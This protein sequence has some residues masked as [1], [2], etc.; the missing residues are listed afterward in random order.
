MNYKTKEDVQRV[1]SLGKNG[2]VIDMFVES[3][4]QG[5]EYEAWIETK[6]SEH[7]TLYPKQID[8]E[9]V[10]DADG[11]TVLYYEQI[12]NP[13]YVDFDTYMSETEQVQVGT[14]DILG[15]DG[16]TVTG[17]EPIY[18]E[19]LLREYV[20]VPV[21]IDEW[22]LD[23]YATLRKHSYPSFEEY[24]DGIVKDDVAQKEAYIQKCKDIKTKYPKRP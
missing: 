19:R 11:V 8:G 12:P 24:I 16:I 23:N 2:N 5:V 10:L 22:K 20:E 21:S 9:A 15:E 6:K 4:L 14:K 18:E 3:Y 1:I 17:T 7:E 13:D